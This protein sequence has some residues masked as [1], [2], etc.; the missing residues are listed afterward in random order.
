MSTVQDGATVQPQR[1]EAYVPVEDR[2][3]GFDRRTILPSVIVL[4]IVALAALVLPGINSATKYDDQVKTGD[5]MNLAE[6]QLIFVPTPGW[7]IVEGQRLATG[8]HVSA[9]SKTVL[10]QQ[11]I[12]F[13]VIVGPFT[14][15]PN[16]LLDQI[17]NVDDKLR[18][19][20]NLGPATKRSNI[21]TTE[22]V[23]GVADFYAGFQNQGLNAALVY[24][25][26]GDSVGTEVVVRGSDIALT[27]NVQSIT[28]MILSIST[29]AKVP[30]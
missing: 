23:P 29:T 30:S 10:E 16:A 13:A 24:Q 19:R 20:T 14:G 26:G 6:G 8:A 4:V 5:V 7:N 15:T 1:A 2:L 21:R 25:I 3:L 28:S 17:N 27:R 12:S 9:S 22:G 18:Q 11:D